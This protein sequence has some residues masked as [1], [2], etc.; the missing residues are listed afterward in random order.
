MKKYLITANPSYFQLRK[1]MP[2]FALYRDKETENYAMQAENFVQMCKPF[3]KLKVFLHQ[4]YALAKKLGA[5]GVHLTSHQFDDI[6]KAKEL[7]LEVIIS[8]HTHDEVHIA[9]AMGADYVTYSPIFA[10]PGKGEPKGVQDLESIVGMVDVNIFALGGILTQEEV[11]VVATTGT[12][13]FA[14]IRY[15][16]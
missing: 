2:D 14:S 6:P 8:T 16:L 4:D 12:Y 13:G 11:D 9:E 1:Y 10:S 7:G 3:K 5:N 15:F